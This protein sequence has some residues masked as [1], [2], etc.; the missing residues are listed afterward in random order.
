MIIADETGC[1]TI[2]DIV[3]K[4]SDHPD[5]VGAAMIM[6]HLT[7][8]VVELR[9][10]LDAHTIV[11]RADPDPE[12]EKSKPTLPSDGD[13]TAAELP[14]TLQCLGGAAFATQV[15]VG[16]GSD[17]RNFSRVDLLRRPG[18]YGLISKSS[19]YIG[20]G[21]DVGMRVAT[22]QQP[23]E[24]VDSV[25][26]IVDARDT[27][28]IDDAKAA[29]RMLWARVHAARE[30]Q[31]VNGVP[32]GVTIDAERY[33][34]LEAFVARACLTLRQHDVFF[35][36]SSA[37]AVLAGPR[38]EPG[39]VGPLRPLDAMPRA[40]VVELNLGSGL[41]ALAARQS[42][43]HW[44]LLQGAEVKPETVRSA[45]AC[46]SYLRASW[47][48]AGP[49]G[50]SYVPTR[51][52]VFKSGSAVAQFCTGSKGKSLAAWRPIDPDGGYDPGTAALVAS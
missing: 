40:D 27:L 39:R 3:A 21:G 30:R 15:F 6:V 44:V 11:Q 45:N 8:L 46:T 51:D 1:T 18:I 10:P 2:G 29:E 34:D 36:Y 37:R 4:R 32:D 12:S 23:I 24:D 50:R 41:I 22:G 38:G 43:Q 7:I 28:S 25:F 31:V 20:M 52:L 19:I 17:R 9:G 47:L 26:V 5:P 14:K 42:E 13:A 16:A 33:S 35:T 48:H 49:G